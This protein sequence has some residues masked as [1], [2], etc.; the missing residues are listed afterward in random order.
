MD[1]WSG[2]ALQR[3]YEDYVSRCSELEARIFARG[4]FIWRRPDSHQAVIAWAYWREMQDGSSPR[5]EFYSV[6]GE[7]YEMAISALLQAT[8]YFD[9]A[10]RRFAQREDDVGGRTMA[11]M[12]PFPMKTIEACF[13]NLL[14]GRLVPDEV[15]TD[16]DKLREAYQLHDA[17][18]LLAPLEIFDDDDDVFVGEDDNEKEPPKLLLYNNKCYR[19]RKRY[20]RSTKKGWYYLCKNHRKCGCKGSIFVEANDTVSILS[21]HAP[22]CTE[23]ES[24]HRSMTFEGAEFLLS[25]KRH[26]AVNPSSPC[27]VIQDF[28]NLHPEFSDSFRSYDIDSLI[29]LLE[30]TVADSV[31]APRYGKASDFVRMD[32]WLA[33]LHIMVIG[34]DEMLA[35]SRSVDWIMFDGT[36]KCVPKPFYQL[37]TVLGCSIETRRFVPLVHFLLPGKKQA[38]Y[39]AMFE[40]LDIEIAF[41]R[42]NRITADFEKG[43]QNEILLWVSRNQMEATL[44]GCRFH[45]V[46]ALRKKMR[47]IYGRA[48]DKD[49]KV[50]TLFH[51]IT[52]FPFLERDVVE[53]FVMELN[54]RE[55][56]I[57]KFLRYFVRFWMPR[58][59]EWAINNDRRTTNNAIESYHSILTERMTKHPSIGRFLMNL[60]LIDAE[61][62][63]NAVNPARQSEDNAPVSDEIIFQFQEALAWFPM[64]TKPNGKKRLRR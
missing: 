48:I 18:P 7:C 5:V 16:V 46:Q 10:L 14:D 30:D 32:I 37:V 27:I 4:D 25:L 26:Q 24:D 33:S 43:L 9:R 58:Y 22:E 60:S 44:H 31:C 56:G 57:D 28:L 13:A 35:C 6:D 51:L 8:D 36:F 3:I 50:K 15:Q 20:A 62:M 61:R 53:N 11:I 49:L 42:V 59:D 47:S 19:R 63:R 41:D 34:S 21:E 12:T 55:T 64:K 38:M 40:L 45:F 39:R 23:M 52:W 2:T 29:S 17:E 54:R 1:R